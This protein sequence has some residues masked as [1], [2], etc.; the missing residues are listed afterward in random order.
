MSHRGCHYQLD[1]MISYGCELFDVQA[2]KK[3]HQTQ[4]SP[5]MKTTIEKGDIKTV[6]VRRFYDDVIIT[7]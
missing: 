1:P 6:P 3:L 5:L 2:D 7:S 4:K